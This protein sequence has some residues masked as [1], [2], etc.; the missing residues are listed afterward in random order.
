MKNKSDKIIFI[1]LMLI[2]SICYFFSTGFNNIS[3]LLWIAPIPIFIYSFFNS[4]K[5]TFILAFSSFILGGLSYYKYFN[6]FPSIIFSILEYSLFFSVIIILC[7]FLFQKI[8]KWYVIFFPPSCYSLYEY[9]SSLVSKNGTI[10]SLS[11]TQIDFQLL[12]QLASITGIYGIT[13][14]L[15]FLP[16]AVSIFIYYLILKNKKNCILVFIF[17]ILIMICT[18][19]FGYSRI[20]ILD[21]HSHENIIIGMASADHL[22]SFSIINNEES[23][24]KVIEHYISLIPMLSKNGAKIILFPEKITT[25]N[26]KILSNISKLLSDAAI[27]Y[28]VT[29]ILGIRR[30]DSNNIF[31]NSAWIFSENGNLISTYDK[32]FLLPYYEVNT[33]YNIPEITPGKTFVTFNFKDSIFGIAICK[34][35]DFQKITHAYSKLNAKV[36]FVPALDFIKDGWFHGRIAIFRGIEGGFSVVRAPSQGI[37][38]ASDEA[39]RIIK[40]VATSSSENT[41]FIAKV[42]VGTSNTI[43]SQYKYLFH[44]FTGSIIFLYLIL[45]LYTHF[46]VSPLKN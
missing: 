14:I 23:S 35:M 31:Y 4:Y 10:N 45:F 9:C 41:Y 7:K 37:L 42:P 19:L 25:I 3:F 33:I 5:R 17:P 43:F 32:H 26:Y 13:F 30:I 11:Y 39:G 29:I 38:M 20:K 22:N 12:I 24:K 18:I 27:K 28:N 8:R 21:S 34:D 15:Y 2:S 40:K 6:D 1:I 16:Y 44:F 36:M 46:K